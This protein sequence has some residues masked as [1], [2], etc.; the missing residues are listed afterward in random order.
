MGFDPQYASAGPGHI[1]LRR[2]L[3]DSFRRGDTLYDFGAEYLDCKRT[4]MTRS[5]T[6]YRLTHFPAA[7]SRV[8]LLRLKRWVVDRLFGH[9]YVVCAKL[10]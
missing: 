3:E 2:A 8:Q 5:R 9:R 1:I 10:S 7:I 4:W 6:S